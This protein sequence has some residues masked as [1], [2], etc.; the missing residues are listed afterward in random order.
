MKKSLLIVSMI[1]GTF[2]S[3]VSFANEP[4]TLQALKERMAKMEKQVQ[5]LQAEVKTLKADN[6]TLSTQLDEV[7]KT[8][9]AAVSKSR[10]LVIDRRGSKQAYLQ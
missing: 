10:K 7:K 6:N 2:F 3:T 4:D 5:Q 8:S 1:A 9:P